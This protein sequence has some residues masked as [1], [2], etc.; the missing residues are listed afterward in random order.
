MEK[1][2]ACGIEITEDAVR[3]CTWHQGR[4]PHQPALIDNILLDPYKARFYNVIQ[5]IKNFFTKDDC[6]CGHK[7]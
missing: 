2:N 3:A 1:C 4:C 6:D 5:S 7:H